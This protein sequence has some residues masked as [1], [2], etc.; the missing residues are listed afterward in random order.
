[1]N[2][3]IIG[4]ENAGKPISNNAPVISFFN[5]SFALRGCR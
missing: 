4:A 5:I 3:E 2:S 1:M